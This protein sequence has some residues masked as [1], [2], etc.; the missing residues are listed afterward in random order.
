VV[1]SDVT[2]EQR[3]QNVVAA[4]KVGRVPAPPAPKG[5]VPKGGAPPLFEI[6]LKPVQGV[7]EARAE[8]TLR[9][10]PA[11]NG[12]QVQATT[13]IQ[14]TPQHTGVGHIDV[15]LPR[16]H[17]EPL[18]GFR[19]PQLG[20]PVAAPW[21]LWPGD[22]GDGLRLPA[23]YE[24]QVEGATLGPVQMLGALRVARVHLTRDQYKRFTVILTGTYFL[25]R[26][27]QKARLELPRP[28]GVLDRGGKV[29]VQAEGGLELLPVTGGPPQSDRLQQITVADRMPAYAELAWRPYRPEFP[30]EVVTDI[31]LYD[32]HARVRQRW[33]FPTTDAA[34]PPGLLHVHVPEAAEGFQVLSGGRSGRDATRD[35]VW[36]QL[37]E[38]AGRNRKDRWEPL[39]TEYTFALPPARVPARK[40]ARAFAVPLPW[41]QE[42]TR[43]SSKVRVWCKPGATPALAPAVPGDAA[44]QD[45]GTEVVPGRDSLPA[46]VVRGEGT[47]PPLRLALQDAPPEPPANLLIERALVQVLLEEG[48]TQFYRA[49]FRLSKLHANT[50]DV[51]LPAPVSDSVTGHAAVSALEVLLDGKKVPWRFP[52]GQRRG[53]HLTAL[54]AGAGPTVL[55]I[56]YRLLPG[57][58]SGEAIP[59]QTVLHPPVLAG[60]TYLGRVRWQIDVAGEEVALS[61][62]P[63]E[64]LF[65]NLAWEWRGWLWTPR[66]ALSGGDLEAWLTGAPGTDPRV[67]PSLVCWQSTLE[68][69]R[70]WHPSRQVW[71]LLCSLLCLAVGMVL[72]LAGAS[73]TTLGRALFWTTA[74]G[75]GL[76]AAACLLFWPGLLAM[77]LYGAQPGAAVLVLVLV[78]QWLLH[79][80]YRR[81]VVFM[82]GFTRVKAGSSLIR[83]SSLQGRPREPS[84]ID[85]PTKP[86]ANE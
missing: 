73:A 14:A 37:Q 20:F 45:E 38:P 62:S 6:E 7:V 68:P 60:A 53:L 41:P 47:R 33:T 22:D 76:G 75:L 50:L 64:G 84:T 42:A 57:Q 72:A 29:T 16:P 39:L 19:V 46:L 43:V 11:E 81:Q 65:P 86:S 15:Q 18:A 82:P 35:T 9:V 71:L 34:A 25:P 26:D 8:H 32:R 1:P 2:E 31:D 40:G 5:K 30:V 59:G 80:R 85:G 44:W 67:F 48:G 78:V 10:R 3:R 12:W 70:V 79:Q 56:A 66:P 69:L 83:S 55:E 61:P 21:P 63:P 51:E 17:L 52:D 36:V 54:P 24:Y 77:L 27:V 74:A 13:R 28:Q 4:F 49:R 58:S 23:E